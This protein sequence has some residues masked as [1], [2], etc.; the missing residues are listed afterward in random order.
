MIY[1]LLQDS[2]SYLR[3]ADEFC[4][5]GVPCSRPDLAAFQA[6]SFIA[7]IFCGFTGFYAWHISETPHKKIPNTVEGRIFAYLKESQWLGTFNFSFQLWDFFI[8]L[9]IPEHTTPIMLTHHLLAGLGGYFC[10][11]YQYLHYYGAFFLGCSEI[12]SIFLVFVDFSRYFPPIEGT[13]YHTF[14]ELCKPLFAITFFY[15]RVLLWTKVSYEFWTDC[16]K[17]LGSGSHDR[18]RPGKRYVCYYFLGIN[19]VLTLMQFYWFGLILQ[20]AL[21]LFN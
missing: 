15:Y 19:I 9:S 16:A 11:E 21:I 17:S 7:I 1:Y 20:E 10:M 13:L 2:A 5:E 14:V 6:S 18:Y 4:P 8:S 12:S 3:P